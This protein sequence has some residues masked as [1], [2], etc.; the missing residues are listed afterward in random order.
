MKEGWHVNEWRPK[1]M[2]E[3]K[4]ADLKEWIKVNTKYEYN[5]YMYIYIECIPPKA[6]DTRCSFNEG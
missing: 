2:Y 3:W 6:E 4:A 5:I 1:W